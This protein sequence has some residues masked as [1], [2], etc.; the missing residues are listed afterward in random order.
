M[1]DK[2]QITK[3]NSAKML[4]LTP[5]TAMLAGQ[6]LIKCAQKGITMLIYSGFRTFEQ[7]NELYKKYL[8]GGNLAARA[9]YSYHN[10][11]L[12][13]DAVPIV[14]CLPDWNS[15]KW[16]EI[17]KIAS[18]VGL[19][20]G[21][22]FN[23]R[24]HFQNSKN[25]NLADLRSKNSGWKKYIDQEQAMI[26]GSIKDKSLYKYVAVLSGCMFAIYL[27]NKL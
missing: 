8:A 14:N 6:L 11:R 19:V 17:G 25:V 13:F 16:N 18:D 22:S 5:L 24:V 2:N 23:D 21:G 4:E 7:Q 26:K 9:G 12:A 1:F 10:Y 15:P 20:W 3:Q 27:L